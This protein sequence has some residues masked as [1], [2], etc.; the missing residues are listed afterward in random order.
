LS[1]LA[2]AVLAILLIIALTLLPGRVIDY[3][4]KLFIVISG[5]V[6]LTSLLA[7]AAY[8]YLGILKP[9]RAL[10][11]AI[12]ETCPPAGPYIDR[13]DDLKD[14]LG[15]VEGLIRSY[16]EIS[17]RYQ[18]LAGALQKPLFE[19]DP[20]G[21]CV[22]ANERAKSLLVGLKDHS[23]ALFVEDGCR[24]KFNTFLNDVRNGG[25]PSE[26]DTVLSSPDGRRVPVKLS[27]APVLRGG[28]TTGLIVTAESAPE[29][30]SLT[31]E[32]KRTKIEADKTAERLRKTID[33]LEEFA[34]LAVRREL[35][36]RE[37]RERLEKM[38]DRVDAG[39]TAAP[40]AAPPV[41]A[42]GPRGRKP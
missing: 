37:I 33:D 25:P 35:K 4:L 5:G 14:I 3:R 40:T 12:S 6:A 34:L 2:V 13:T 8:V 7:A 21:V 36:M 39:P 24:G 42:K 41:P 27:A 15:S 16:G 9:L 29:T 26:L 1:P 17:A 20:S 28:Q 19:L 38:S 23:L 32:L 18:A 11:R 31:A 30:A 10:G 22:N